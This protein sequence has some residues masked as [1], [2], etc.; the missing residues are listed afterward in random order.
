MTRAK[1][2][3]GLAR[4][5][6]HGVVGLAVVAAWLA[7]RGGMEWN[8]EWGWLGIGV[9]AVHS[10]LR[11]ARPK[12]HEPAVLHWSSSELATDVAA[13]PRLAD[14]RSV[15]GNGTPCRVS[16]RSVVGAERGVVSSPN[17]IHH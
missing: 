1:W 16:N 3:L 8:S 10:L 11:I 17:G 12:R 6:P 13:G 14:W 5:L 4:A 2:M 15:M 7:F 9:L